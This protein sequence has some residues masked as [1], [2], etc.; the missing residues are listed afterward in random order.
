MKKYR[1]K[2]N[3]KARKYIVNVQYQFDLTQV[4]KKWHPLQKIMY[5]PLGYRMTR[6]LKCQEIRKN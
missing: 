1:E 3:S 4:Q 5:V 2:N 6:A